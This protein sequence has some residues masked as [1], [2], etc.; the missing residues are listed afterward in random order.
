[1]STKRYTHIHTHNM[2]MILMTKNLNGFHKT[3]PIQ[4]FIL[5]NIINMLNANQTYD[6]H[7]YTKVAHSANRTQM[8]KKS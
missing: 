4:L 1:M 3:L 7:T 2:N 6:T 8:T 5:Q